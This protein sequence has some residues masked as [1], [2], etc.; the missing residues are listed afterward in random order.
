MDILKQRSPDRSPFGFLWQRSISNGFNRC[1]SASNAG[2]DLKQF[3]LN[4]YKSV[5]SQQVLL[6][7]EQMVAL[8]PFRD[9][10]IL[11]NVGHSSNYSAGG[12]CFY[13]FESH[14]TP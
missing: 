5:W 6:Y 12:H 7:N 14:Y 2:F 8:E 4:N 10:L 1:S 13:R 11:A 9:A 3:V